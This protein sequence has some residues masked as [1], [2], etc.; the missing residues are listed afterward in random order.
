MKLLRDLLLLALAAGGWYWWKHQPAPERA[1]AF[2]GARPNL[3][4]PAASA[5]A[6]KVE[7]SLQTLRRDGGPIGL[8][9]KQARE[10]ALGRKP[11]LLGAGAVDVTGGRA[12][13]PLPDEQT[14]W[15]DR[16]HDPKAMAAV[17]ALFIVLY[18]LGTRALRK[19]PGGHGFTH[20]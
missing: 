16:L 2:S 4:M 12:S 6:P 1:P 17:V 11:E 5:A 10:Q 14:P 7:S 8:N 20:D 3:A 19:G 18:A 9:G 15:E 13:E